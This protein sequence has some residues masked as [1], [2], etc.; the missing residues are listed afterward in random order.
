LSPEIWKSKKYSKESDIWALGVILYEMCCLQYP[1]PA[2][3]IE[4]LERK[5]LNDK[6]GKYPTEVSKDFVDMCN[7]MLKKDHARR[8]CIEEIIYSD[9]F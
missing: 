3:E 8:P 6:I 1:F 7:K 5:V 2:T 4:E 9:I